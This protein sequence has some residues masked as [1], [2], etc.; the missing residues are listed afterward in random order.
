MAFLPQ[1]F[2]ANNVEPSQPREVIPAG[3][4]QTDEQILRMHWLAEGVQGTLAK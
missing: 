2:D 4:T 1:T 3:R